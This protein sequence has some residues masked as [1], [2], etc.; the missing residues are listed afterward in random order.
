MTCQIEKAEAEYFSRT[1]CPGLRWIFS[2]PVFAAFQSQAS[3]FARTL[4]QSNPICALKNTN[5]VR[6][7]FSI[8]KTASRF[9]ERDIMFDDLDDRANPFFGIPDHIAARCCP[10]PIESAA[11]SRPCNGGAENHWKPKGCIFRRTAI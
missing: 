11:S 3:S 8:G 7:L 2:Q 6:A 1:H 10:N 5:D 9:K 4:F